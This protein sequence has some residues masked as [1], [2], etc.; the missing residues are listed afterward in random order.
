MKKFGTI[1]LIII[2]SSIVFILGFSYNRPISPYTYYD[3]YLDGNLIGTIESKSE[4]ENYI[5]N[6]GTVIKNNVIDYSEK[7]EIINNTNEVLNSNYSDESLSK[8]ERVNYI[9]N[10]SN[11]SDIKKDYLTQYNDLKLYELS[12]NDIDEMTEYVEKNSIYITAETIYVPNGIEIKKIN[13]Y[14]SEVETVET[15]YKNI[16]LEKSP[17]IAGYKFTVKSETNGE[18]IIYVTDKELFQEAIDSVAS[19]FIGED[20]YKN[21]KEKTQSKIVDTGTLIQEVYVQED[22]SYKAVNIAVDEKIYTDSKE[23]SKYLL[24]GNEYEQSIVTVKAGESITKIAYDNEISIEEFLISNP[25]FT[26]KDNLLYEGKQIIISKIN[27]QINIVVETYSVTDVETN[28]SIVEQYDSTLNQGKEYVSQEGQKG[29]ERV[30]QNVKSINGQIVYIEPISKETIKAPV[31][32]IITVGTKYIPTVGS[33]TSWGWPTNSGYTFSSYYGW[34][35]SP[36]NGK[37]ELHSGLDI[38]GTGH[39]SPIYASNNGVVE[40]VKGEARGNTYGNY[41]MINHGNGYWT[42]YAHMSRFEPG[43]SVGDVVSRGD[44]IGYVGKTGAATGPHLHYEIRKGCNKFSCVTDPLN[45]YR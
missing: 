10:N 4:L 42:L 12:Q 15:V 19:I 21:Y 8:K 11:I 41:I 29:V 13:T 44:V 26:S 1:A 35:I 25:E 9:L 43:I 30:T 23:L 27:P 3:V 24:Y 18:Q 14:D 16:V 7:L 5:N 39:G 38:A 36:I 6:Q 32:K 37:R 33:T 28:Y 31:S 45:Y 40:V 34:R 17:T 20:K 22:I 2:L